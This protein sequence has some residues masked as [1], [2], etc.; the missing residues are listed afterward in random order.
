MKFLFIWFYYM[1]SRTT[2]DKP[3]FEN[4]KNIKL[5]ITIRIL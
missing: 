1:L 5:V 3:L 4:V 2:A